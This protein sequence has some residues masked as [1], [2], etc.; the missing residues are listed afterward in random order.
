MKAIARSYLW[1]PGLDRDMEKVARSCLSCQAVKHV[2]PLHP[3]MW[4]NYPWQRVHDF[5]GP[6]QGKM[7]LLAVDAHSKW[8]E[9]HEMSQTTAT[10]NISQLRQMFAAYGLPDRIVLDNGP[11]FVSDEY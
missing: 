3:W 11:Q 5:V 7:F 6:F 2:A 10:K 9:I 4:P 8:G 1:W